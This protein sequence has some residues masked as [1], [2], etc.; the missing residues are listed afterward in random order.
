MTSRDFCY[1]LQGYLELRQNKDAALEA[2]QV[3]CIAKHLAMVFTH[4]IDPSAGPREQ[5]QKLDAIH[6]Q[7]QQ[8]NEAVLQKQL[9]MNQHQHLTNQNQF[10]PKMRC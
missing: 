2:G 4:E 3:Q 7:T 6:N 9:A 5:Q 1:W 10:G 8:Q